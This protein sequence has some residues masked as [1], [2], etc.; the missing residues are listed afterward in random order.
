MPAKSESQQRLMGMVYAYKKGDLKKK[1]VSSENLW[2]KIKKIAKNISKKDAEKYASTK[3][4][5]IPQEVK[6]NKIL[7][8]NEF[9][10]EKR[11]N[12]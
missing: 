9:V 6:E 12:I 2:N 7:R 4:K 8:F 11:K 10:N 1:D 5:N 3:H